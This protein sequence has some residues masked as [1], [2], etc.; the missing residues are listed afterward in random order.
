MKIMDPTSLGDWLNLAGVIFG[1]AVFVMIGIAMFSPA[2]EP[3]SE[4]NY[5][6]Y[7]A[8]DGATKRWQDY[9]E[10]LEEQGREQEAERKEACARYGWCD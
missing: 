5:P 6:T 9:E 1:I 4:I 2:P 10:Y 7:P 3:S 8:G